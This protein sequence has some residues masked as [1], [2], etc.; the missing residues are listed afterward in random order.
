M[1]ALRTL[2]PACTPI[3]AATAAAGGMLYS[4]FE[5]QKNWLKVMML[6]KRGCTLRDNLDTINSDPLKIADHSTTQQPALAAIG[7]QHIAI[8][9][10]SNQIR[11][12][13]CCDR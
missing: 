10:H 11:C 13:T 12:S 4:P 9:T 8:L 6:P 3:A 1:V 7:R 5:L 2:E